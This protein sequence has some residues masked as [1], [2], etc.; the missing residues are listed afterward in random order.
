MQKEALKIFKA[1]NEK[2]VASELHLQDEKERIR[3]IF[4]YQTRRLFTLKPLDGHLE[5]LPF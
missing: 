5:P 2:C 4:N 3:N 1:G